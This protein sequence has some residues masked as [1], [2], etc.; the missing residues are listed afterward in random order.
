MGKVIEYD[1]KRKFFFFGVVFLTYAI[2][3]LCFKFGMSII[4]FKPPSESLRYNSFLKDI[5]LTE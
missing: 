2:A 5:I 4:L 1:V 3:F